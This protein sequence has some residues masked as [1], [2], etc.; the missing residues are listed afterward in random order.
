MGTAGAMSAEEARAIRLHLGLTEGELGFQLNLTPAIIEA[1]EAGD[2]RIPK[3]EADFLR[4]LSALRE[5]QE[6]L[7]S[8]GL[9]VCDWVATWESQAPAKSLDAETKR[10]EALNAHAGECSTC[11]ARES[12]LQARFGPMPRAPFHGWLRI[13]GPI[14]ERIERL[15]PWAQPPA[16]MALVF[17]AYTLLRGLLQAQRLM[18]DPAAASTFLLAIPLT[19]GLGAAV[20]FLVTAWRLLRGRLRKR[21][22]ADPTT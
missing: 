16:S 17:L 12:F 15:P 18:D 19:I 9:P 8:S 4:Y 7:E 5:R 10:L 6:A 11:L 22:V 3:R 20:G 14:V 21:T 13:V 1:F 2:V